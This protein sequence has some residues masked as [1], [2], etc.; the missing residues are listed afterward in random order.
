M[1]E[2]LPYGSPQSFEKCL[3]LY[4][5]NNVLQL[6]VSYLVYLKWSHSKVTIK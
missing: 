4:F 6:H 5:L 1:A 2:N 3:I